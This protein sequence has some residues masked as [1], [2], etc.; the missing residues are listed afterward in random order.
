[1]DK[2]IVIIKPDGS[3]I[4]TDRYC[5]AYE[6]DN[7]GHSRTL[8][9]APGEV[10]TEFNIALFVSMFRRFAKVAAFP[11]EKRAMLL[12]VLLSAFCDIVR[13][14]VEDLCEDKPRVEE[15]AHHE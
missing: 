8:C 5:V 2:S 13:A 6:Q 1:M 12:D 7:D 15:E 9:H 10:L 14:N 11:A 4:R 3:S